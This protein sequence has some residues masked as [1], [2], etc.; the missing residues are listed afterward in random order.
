MREWKSKQA[1]YK[2]NTRKN[3]AFNEISC[4]SKNPLDIKS[5]GFLRKPKIRFELTTPSLRVKCSTG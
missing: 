1:R 4:K 3:P 2:E 5:R